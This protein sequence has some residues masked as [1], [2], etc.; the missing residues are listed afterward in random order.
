V[1]LPQRGRREDHLSEWMDD[2]DCDPKLLART[3]EAFE[4]VNRWIGRWGTLAHRHI[5]PL[6]VEH[7]QSGQT[8]PFRV[9]DVGAGG[10]DVLRRLRDLLR[11]SPVDLE[12]SGADPDLRAIQAARRL[13]PERQ[14]CPR[15]H[16]FQNR[17]EDLLAA[18]ERFDLVLSNHV[19]HHLGDAAVTPFLRTLE[20]LARRRVL[21]TDIARSRL[22]YVGFSI[23]SRILFPG[24]LIREDGCLSIRRSF[25]P[26]ELRSLLPAGW[27]L[28]TLVPYRLVLVRDRGSVA[29]P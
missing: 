8:R 2:P 3:Y 6:L 13:T 20:G 11:G 4:S 18:G 25:R 17:A 10:G 9:L 15:V 14:G 5:F 1:T 21:V 12:L 26:E 29:H 28:H 24:T 27:S 19:V 22:G 23:A 16:W 7:A